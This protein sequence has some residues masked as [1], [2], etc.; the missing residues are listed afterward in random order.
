MPVFLLAS[1]FGQMTSQLAKSNRGGG[2]SNRGGGKSQVVK[3]TQFHILQSAGI[4]T[5]GT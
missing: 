4:D 5:T 3:D 2:S 1:L